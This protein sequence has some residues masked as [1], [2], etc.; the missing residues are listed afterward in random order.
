MAGMKNRIVFWLGMAVTSGLIGWAVFHYDFGA[1]RAALGQ[2][3]YLWVA[4]AGLVQMLLLLI[5]AVRWRHYSSLSLSTSHVVKCF[6]KEIDY[7]F[8]DL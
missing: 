5:R 2:A 4:A 6:F 8:F 1:V 3:N 7:F